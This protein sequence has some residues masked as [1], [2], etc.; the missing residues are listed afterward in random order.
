M[1]GSFKVLLFQNILPCPLPILAHS[2]TLAAKLTF[3]LMGREHSPWAVV[4][5]TTGPSRNW[6]CHCSGNRSQSSFWIL[7]GKREGTRL[8]CFQNQE[9]V[10]RLGNRETLGRNSHWLLP[11]LLR[12][13]N[14]HVLDSAYLNKAQLQ[15]M[16]GVCPDLD[17]LEGLL[18]KVSRWESL[19]VK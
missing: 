7:G 19:T 3:W 12:K 10:L 14:T 17:Y 16:I 11:S 9:P 6:C 18:V 8:R 2:K 4:W 13:A 15:S 5:R 1:Q